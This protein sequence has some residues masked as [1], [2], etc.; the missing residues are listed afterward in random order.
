ME[1]NSLRMHILSLREIRAP[2]SGS[3]QQHRK[4]MNLRRGGS[5]GGALPRMIRW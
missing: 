3:N 2:H 4:G 1:F 5:C